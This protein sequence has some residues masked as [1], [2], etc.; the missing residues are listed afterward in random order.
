MSASTVSSCVTCDWWICFSHTA[1][2][3]NDTVIGDPLFKA[4]VWLEEERRTSNLCYQIHGEPNQVF[5]LVSD[6]CVAV[7]ARYVSM[8]NPN[9]GNIINEIGI[10]A[11]GTSNSCFNITVRLNNGTCQASRTASDGSGDTS[12]SSN[13]DDS[14]NGIFMRQRMPTRVRISVPNCE[15]IPLVM[16]VTC[17]TI[18][19]QEMIRF[20]ISRGVNLRP[21]SHGL[22]GGFLL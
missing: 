6:E 15:Q 4:A 22:I 21:T 9:D 5:S 2:L 7:N 1:V 8:N 18:G 11:A 12:Y 10:V 20:D 17:E 14:F 16:W 3:A 13:F 19:G